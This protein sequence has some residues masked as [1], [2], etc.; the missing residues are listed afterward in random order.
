M[1]GVDEMVARRVAAVH[2]LDGDRQARR[3]F[4]RLGGRVAQVRDEDPLR[5]R[6]AGHAGHH[7]HTLRAEGFRPGER[8]LEAVAKGALPPRQRRESALAALP[9]AGGRADERKLQPQ[10]LN[11]RADGV[12]VEM[13]EERRFDAAEARGDR[14]LEALDHRPFCEHGGDVRA[15]TRHG[16]SLSDRGAARADP[17]HALEIPRR[18]L[19]AATNSC[20][21]S[22]RPSIPSV[23]TS[24]AVKNAGGFWPRPTPSGVPVAMMSPTRSVM[25]QL[26]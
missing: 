12:A 5:L 8:G 25:N 1:L 21:C 6:S 9:I 3:F 2:R 17:A 10:P 14:G 19:G 22:P 11:L 13:I 7:V 15:K 4:A 26:M 24:P 18:Q 20:L 16:S 23:T